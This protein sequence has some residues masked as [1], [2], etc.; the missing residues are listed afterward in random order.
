MQKKNY[1]CENCDFEFIVSHEASEVYQ[2][3]YCPFCSAT[4]EKAEWYDC[5]TSVTEDDEPIL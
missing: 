2:V 5:E 1:L 4:L 3:Q